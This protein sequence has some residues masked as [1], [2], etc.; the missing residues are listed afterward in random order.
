[1]LDPKLHTKNMRTNS[2]NQSTGNHIYEA[3]E[4]QRINDEEDKKSVDDEDKMFS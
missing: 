3:Q 2:D 1:M 4:L